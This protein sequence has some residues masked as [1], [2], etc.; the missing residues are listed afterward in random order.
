MQLFAPS[1]GR[2]KALDE[3]SCKRHAVHTKASPN[4]NGEQKGITSMLQRKVAG[5]ASPCPVAH[6]RHYHECLLPPEITNFRSRDNT[7]PAKAALPGSWCLQCRRGC[8]HGTGN[9]CAARGNAQLPE[10]VTRTSPGPET[11]GQCLCALGF[12]QHTPHHRL[13]WRTRG[14]S[15]TAWQARIWIS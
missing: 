14:L 3:L 13:F 10:A 12:S 7:S 8:Q 6:Y 15:T 2:G 11:A 9:A 5:L 4:V 1:K